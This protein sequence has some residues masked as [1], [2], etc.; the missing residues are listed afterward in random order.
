MITPQDAS[1]VNS[2]MKKAEDNDFDLVF[3]SDV[4]QL[5][6]SSNTGFISFYSVEELYGFMCGYEWG[7]SNGK[8]KRKK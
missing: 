1:M 3:Y 8:N 6:I 2:A 4:I 5:R 7:F